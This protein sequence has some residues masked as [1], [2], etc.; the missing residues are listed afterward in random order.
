V[1]YEVRWGEF[2]AQRASEQFG[3]ERSD[4]GT[5]SEQD[6]FSGPLS[7]ALQ[8]FRRFD[9]LVVEAGPSVRSLQTFDPIFGP[10][11]FIGVLVGDRVVEIADFATDPDYWSTIDED[12]T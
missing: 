7:A 9:S 12:P 8:G 6:F 5:P 1:T 4:D 11:T 2:A 3:G 10:V